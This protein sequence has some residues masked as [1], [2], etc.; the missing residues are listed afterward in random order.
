VLATAGYN[1]VIAVGFAYSGS[2]AKVAKEMPDTKFAIID[3]AAAV[4]DNIANL[5]FASEQGSYLVGVAAALKTKTN[6]IGFVGGVDVP[7]DQHLPG[8]LRGRR[9][10]REPEGEGPGQVPDPAPGLLRLR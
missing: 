9:Q 1:P 7:L 5:L 10:G 2:V 6:N 3:D 4:G 8:R